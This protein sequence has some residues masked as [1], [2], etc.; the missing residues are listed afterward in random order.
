MIKTFY[1]IGELEMC[2]LDYEFTDH[3]IFKIL[4]N[5]GELADE[6]AA[7]QMQHFAKNWF[8][9]PSREIAPDQYFFN[10][11]VCVTVAGCQVISQETYDELTSNHI[12]SDITGRY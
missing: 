12:M 8:S 5:D 9:S 4:E 6:K 7:K 2:L 3:F 1:Y 10:G 11:E